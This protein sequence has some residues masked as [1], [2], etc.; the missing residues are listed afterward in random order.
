MEM[1]EKRASDGRILRL[2]K[3]I[4]VG[5]IDGRLL[6]TETG[7]GQAGDFTAANIYLHYA[8]WWSRRR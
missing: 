4:N 8:R 3:W 7:T 6:V 5:A 2:I 1:I